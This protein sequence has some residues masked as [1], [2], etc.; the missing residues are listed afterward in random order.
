MKEDYLVVVDMQKDFIDGALG[1]AE[2]R[3]IVPTVIDYVN[4]FRGSV[5]FTQD[6]HGRDYLQT[7]EGKNLPIVHCV[8]GTA[9]WNLEPTLDAFANRHG[10]RI[11]TKGT[12]GSLELA[13]FL[14]GKAEDGRVASVTLLG[15]CT[16]ICVVSNAMLIKSFLPEVP[17]SVV[18]SCS[19]GVTPEKHREALDVMASCHISIIK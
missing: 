13:S 12:F 15:L 9:G 1:T 19:A 16:D 8:R 14:R 10:C 17:V 7:Q 3:A 11:F 18:A 5:V 4:S 6:T 2:A